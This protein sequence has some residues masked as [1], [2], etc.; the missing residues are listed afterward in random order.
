[1]NNKNKSSLPPQDFTPVYKIA[2]IILA[3]GILTACFALVKIEG[4]ILQFVILSV[5]SVLSAFGII[6]IFA[7][8]SAKK[9]TGQGRNYFLYDR[10]TKKNKSV[11]SLTLLDIRL[12]IQ[13]YMSLFRRG[14]RLYVGDLFNNDIQIPPAIRTLFCYELLYEISESPASS[15]KA[16]LFL[17]FGNEC[18][19]VFYSYLSAAGETQ[20]AEKIRGYFNEFSESENTA[21]KFHRFLDANRPYLDAAIVKYTKDHIDEF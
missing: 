11:D 14:K 1:M 5:G 12:K 21:E 6:L 16:K 7:A 10:K 9:F 19:D 18:A 13:K 15:D 20:L 4:P 17:S 3:I 8:R 2:A